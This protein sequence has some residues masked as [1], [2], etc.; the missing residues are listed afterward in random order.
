MQRYRPRVAG[1]VAILL[2]EGGQVGNQAQRKRGHLLQEQDLVPVCNFAD[3]TVR[4]AGGRLQV[5]LDLGDVRQTAAL[6]IQHPDDTGRRGWRELVRSG[7]LSAPNLLLDLVH[8][9]KWQ[10]LSI[11]LGE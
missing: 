7:P 5:L 9:D 4:Q 10:G 3:L 1:I 8:D 11:V 2:F 6:V